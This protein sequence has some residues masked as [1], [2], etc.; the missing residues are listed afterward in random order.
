[1]WS[2]PKCY[3]QGTWLELS[4]FCTGVCEEETSAR[5]AEEFRLLEAAPRERPE[6]TQQ[7]G[8]GLARAVVICELWIL[9]VAL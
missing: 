6:K 1:M 9:A 3:K 7:D 4:Q 8:E 5:E 2:V